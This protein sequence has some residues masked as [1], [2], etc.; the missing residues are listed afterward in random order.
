MNHLMLMKIDVLNKF[1]SIKICE[2]YEIDG[3]QTDKVPYETDAVI[4]PI[5]SEIKGWCEDIAGKSTFD[6]L[7]IAMKEYVNA[8]EQRMNLPIAVV[9]TSPDRKDTIIRTEL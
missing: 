8:I 4:N 2:Q 1:E 9:S 7:P 3:N 5:Y 6:Q